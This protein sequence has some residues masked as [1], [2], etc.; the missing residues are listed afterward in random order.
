MLVGLSY[1]ELT[2]T[3]AYGAYA[4]YSG[5]VDVAVYDA[6]G[7]AYYGK[8]TSNL[9]EWQDDGDFLHWKERIEPIGKSVKNYRNTGRFGRISVREGRLQVGVARQTA[10]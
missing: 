2:D 5:G 4:D 6:N 10:V 7:L 3:S 1:V 9:Q 8:L